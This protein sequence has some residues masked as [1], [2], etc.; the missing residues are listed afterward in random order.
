MRRAL[1][2]LVV[3]AL[4]R[5]AGVDQA[6]LP[7]TAGVVAAVVEGAAAND[8][9]MLGNVTRCVTSSLIPIHSPTA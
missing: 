8:D 2:W 1:D 9:S 3:D 5:A 4:G 7:A 6:V